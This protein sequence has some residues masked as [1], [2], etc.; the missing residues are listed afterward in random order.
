MIPKKDLIFSICLG[1]ATA[2]ILMLLGLN[3]YSL[4][5]WIGCF[6]LNILGQVA[7]RFSDEIKSFFIR[8]V[9]DEEDIQH[10]RN[11]LDNLI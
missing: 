10:N 11:D 1:L 2:L 7:Y 6:T 3:V 9:E 8:E 4:L 5:W